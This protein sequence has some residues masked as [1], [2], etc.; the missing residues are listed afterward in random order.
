MNYLKTKKKVFLGRKERLKGVMPRERAA[1]VVE[2]VWKF[3]SDSPTEQITA[4][5]TFL[6]DDEVQY[7]R[8]FLQNALLKHGQYI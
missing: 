7:V 3:H 6:S 1:S 8:T 2:M 4:N 5:H